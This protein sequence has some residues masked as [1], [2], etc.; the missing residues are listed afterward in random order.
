VTCYGYLHAASSFE[1]ARRRNGDSV[2]FFVL[3]DADRRIEFNGRD[4]TDSIVGSM[5]SWKFRPGGDPIYY[6]R[7]VARRAP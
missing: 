1:S 2:D 5:N 3:F 4:L 6:G 7:F